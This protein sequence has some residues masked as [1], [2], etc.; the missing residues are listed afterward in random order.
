MNAQLTSLAARRER[1]VAAAKDQRQALV[2]EFAHWDVPLQGIERALVR[3]AWARKHLWWLLAAG[4]AV[5]ASPAVR[6]RLLRGWQLWR[7]VRR[8]QVPAN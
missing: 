6:G 4:L 5:A 7:A 2:G 3:L 1:L 8:W